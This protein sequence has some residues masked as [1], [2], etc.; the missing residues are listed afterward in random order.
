MKFGR[1]DWSCKRGWWSVNS[2]ALRN[3]RMDQVWWQGSEASCQSHRGKHV[4]SRITRWWLRIDLFVDSEAADVNNSA[5]VV[6]KSYRFCGNASGTCMMCAFFHHFSMN[7]LFWELHPPRRPSGRMTAA[8]NSYVF[9][10]E[11]CT[12]RSK[13]SDSD[14]VP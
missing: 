6:A 13:A 1:Q 9:T 10:T 8:E 12:W 14:E 11:F 2:L 4:G 5:Y 3:G 7:L